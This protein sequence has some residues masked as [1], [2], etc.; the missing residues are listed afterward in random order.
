MDTTS[1]P[2]WKQIL[3][4]LA[5]A[6]V[7]LVLYGGYATTAP[8]LQAWLIA[9]QSQIDAVQ[10]GSATV[11]SVGISETKYN[12]FV[13]RSQE[14]YTRFAADNAP[15]PLRQDHALDV[16]APSPVAPSAL[17]P[18]PPTGTG[19]SLVKVRTE[20]VTPPPAK[21]YRVPAKDQSADRRMEKTPALPNSGI[22]LWFAVCLAGLTAGGLVMRRRMHR[23]LFC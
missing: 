16:P 9:P 23:G 18:P 17:P 14:I 10:P 1:T 6:G 8:H 4:A 13:A 3:G 7:A 11:N 20:D 15:L 2:F 19:G 12:R 5:G 22:G 21:R